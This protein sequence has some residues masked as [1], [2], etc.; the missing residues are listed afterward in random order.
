[1]ANQYII[2]DVENVKV[3]YGK[4]ST[5]FHRNEV[6]NG[7]FFCE[8]LTVMLIDSIFKMGKNYLNVY[9][10]TFLENSNIN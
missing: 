10:Q 9:P 1:M 8:Y 6:S 4:I 5:D 2:T 3:F 7:V